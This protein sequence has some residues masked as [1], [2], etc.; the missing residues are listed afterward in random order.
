[1]VSESIIDATLG[2]QLLVTD[3]SPA[4]FREFLARASLRHHQVTDPTD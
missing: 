1:V 2:A 3:T 4:N